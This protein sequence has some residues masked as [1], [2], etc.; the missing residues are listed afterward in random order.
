MNNNVVY[1][2]LWIDDEDSIVNSMQ[3]KA[4]EYNLD[5]SDHCSNWTDA[6]K[7]LRDNFDEYSA[8]ILD[9]FCKKDE[10]SIEIEDF[11]VTLFNLL[12]I[13]EKRQKYI[14]WY[15]L[16]AGNGKFTTEY[17]SSVLKS[18][19][20]IRGKEIENE[21]GGLLF[22]IVAPPGNS[23]AIDALF[24]KIVSV[25]QN[26]TQNVILYRYKDVFCNMGDNK[27]IDKRA[28]KTLMEALSTLYYPEEKAYFKF[29]ENPL[30]KVLE[31]VF[32]AANK[33]GLIPDVLVKPHVNLTFCSKFMAGENV[34]LDE[35][36]YGLR[37]GKY[38]KKE[39]NKESD[40]IFPKDIATCVRNSLYYTQ[41]GSHT[42]NIEIEPLLVEEERK[43]LFFGHVMHICYVIRWFGKYVEKH[44][45][46]DENIKMH[47][48][49]PDG[50][51]DEN[52]TRHKRIPNGRK[53]ENIKIH[54]ITLKEPPQNDDKKPKEKKEKL[55]HTN[56]E[57]TRE[58]TLNKTY[59]VI[60]RN[61]FYSAGSYKLSPECKSIVE[62]KDE[63]KIIE[64]I[65]NNDKDKKDFPYIATKIEIIKAE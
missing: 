46:K 12:R 41:S 27:I 19:E 51:K 3:S 25:A 16:T 14:P 61:Y 58:N 13:F 5:L 10:N 34:T 53:D 11:I 26:S 57:I 43:E 6:E 32:K 17:Y 24:S 36:G 59:H 65:E 37:W 52:I 42:E 4:Q 63:I 55:T 62:L 7:C 35:K 39:D 40:S 1:K 20:K 45:N 50:H 47:N 33:Y 56:E 2:V 22:D 64:K 38:R 30:R 54:Q 28:R 15:I 29:E 49:I 60:N 9:I 18:A 44:N 23:N 48:R 21:W 31:Y 8:I